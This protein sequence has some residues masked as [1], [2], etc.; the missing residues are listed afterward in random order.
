[1]MSTYELP[2][3][4]VTQNAECRKMPKNAEKCRKMPNMPKNAEK[5]RKCRKMT[6]NADK[7]RKMP[8]N[9]E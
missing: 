8:K 5:C 3:V 6:K 2:T 9:A 4:K 1:M 7:C